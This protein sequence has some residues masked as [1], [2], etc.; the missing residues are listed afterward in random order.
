MVACL[1]SKKH[2]SKRHLVHKKRKSIWGILLRS[3][4]RERTAFFLN[5]HFWPIWNLTMI[6]NS[7]TIQF[8]QKTAN[9]YFNRHSLTCQFH[10]FLLLSYEQVLSGLWWWL[11]TDVANNCQS[12]GG[13]GWTQSPI[14]RLFFILAVYCHIGICS[15][16]LESRVEI[17]V[18]LLFLHFKH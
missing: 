16:D 5:L 14:D 11:P 18:G 12:S 15:H 17:F 1:L 8:L 6:T 3:E 10:L 2:W 7:L 13:Y 9:V 4:G